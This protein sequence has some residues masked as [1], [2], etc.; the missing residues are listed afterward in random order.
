MRANFF[1]NA[2]K[3]AA[4]AVALRL[5]AFLPKPLC[6]NGADGLMQVQLCI[7]EG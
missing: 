6:R 1:R 5:V 7:R 2:E 4:G 3:N